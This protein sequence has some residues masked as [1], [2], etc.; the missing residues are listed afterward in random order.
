EGVQ[1]NDKTHG[2]HYT[3]SVAMGGSTAEKA[4][5]ICPVGWHVP[6]DLEWRQLEMAYGMTSG[7]ANGNNAWRGYNQGTRLKS[8]G[9]SGFNATLSGFNATSYVGSRG[10]YWTSTPNGSS[11]AYYRYF[12]NSNATIYRYYIDKNTYASLRCIKNE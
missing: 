7:Q 11:Y 1:T 8:G 10:Y 5:G 2:V 4:K 9:N 12:L 3:W 6:S